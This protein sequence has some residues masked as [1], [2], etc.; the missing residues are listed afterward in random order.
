MPVTAINTM[1]K[2][3][4]DDRSDA[5]TILE[6]W[7]SKRQLP[8]SLCT[9]SLNERLHNALHWL[10][11]LGDFEA[12]YIENRETHS[13]LQWNHHPNMGDARA[14]A[15]AQ[16][17]P[18]T[19]DKRAVCFT[20]DEGER[21]LHSVLCGNNNGPYVWGA[22]STIQLDKEFVEQ[23]SLLFSEIIDLR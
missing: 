16:L 20:L 6:M 5:F 14:E 1:P 13:L 17:D 10:S 11:L 8:A 19:P 9:G 23:I 15:E 21:Y 12:L 2:H 18:T 4:I 7:E 3:V 22:I